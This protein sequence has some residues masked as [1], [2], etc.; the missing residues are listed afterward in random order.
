MTVQQLAEAL[1]SPE[2]PQLLDVREDAE[3]AQS[4]LQ[5]IIHIPLIHLPDNLDK[6]DPEIPIAVI[7]RLGGRSAHATALLIQE[8]FTAAN[9]AGGMVAWVAEVDPSLPPV[10]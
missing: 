6:L 8:G 9:V 4:A 1:A 7:C 2:P 5:N 3:V 10:A